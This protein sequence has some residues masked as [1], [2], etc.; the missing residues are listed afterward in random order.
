MAGIFYISTFL[1]LS[2]KVFRGQATWSMLLTFFW[3]A[4]PQYVYYI[5][6]LAVLLAA[7]VTIGLLTKN[8]ELVVMKACG[9]SL[10]R[11]ALPMVVSAICAGGV[12]FLLEQTVLGPANRRAEAI[13]HVI[14]G[15]APQTF[16]VLLRRW[17]V[18]SDGD[19]YHFDYYDP[20]AQQLNG[21]SI[22]GFGS[23]MPVLAR[24][25]FAQ[26]AA[27]SRRD[28]R[29]QCVASRTGLGSGAHR[30]GRDTVVHAV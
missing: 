23:R 7:L 13:R 16:D 2:D 20:R 28:H 21:L 14:R 26:R 18:G 4:T 24:R 10:Y 27:Y 30:H 15:G 25:T 12:L 3:Y 22:Y 11:V 19:I 1:D 6:P 29:C 5:L 9:I 17:V 8:S